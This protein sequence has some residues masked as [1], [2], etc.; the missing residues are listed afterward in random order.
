MSVRARRCA[1]ILISALAVALAACEPPAPTANGPE[2]DA[3]ARGQ[4]LVT[5]GGCIDCHTPGYF[6]GMP[7]QTRPL[8]GSD[9]GFYIPNLGTFYGPNLTPD[10]DTGLG[11]WTDE[12]IVAAMRTGA[13][14]D[15]RVLA[16]IMPWMHLANLTDEDATAIVA[17]LRSLPPIRN[18]QEVPPVGPTQAPPAPYMAILPPGTP[19]PMPPGP[20]PGAL[21]PPGAPT[22]PAAAPPVP[23][24]TPPPAPSPQ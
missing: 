8:A 1:S 19:P 24:A 9:V 3:V 17:Y 2:I 10:P 23:G 12:Q 4:Y 18:D 15:G 14:P 11:S 13:R 5:M 21:P 16:P 7:D 6:M 22:D 20:P